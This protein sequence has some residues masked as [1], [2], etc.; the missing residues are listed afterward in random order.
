MHDLIQIHSSTLSLSGLIASFLLHTEKENK[1]KIVTLPLTSA[2][3]LAKF[4]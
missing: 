1:N 3:N 2:K 4:W